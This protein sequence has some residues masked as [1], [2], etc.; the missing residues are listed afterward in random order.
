[1]R[2][3]ANRADQSRRIHSQSLGL[4]FLSEIARK[5]EEEALHFGVESLPGERILD[6]GD[7]MSELILHRLRRDTA[8]RGLEVEVRSTS[9]AMGDG[10]EGSHGW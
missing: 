7:E 2:L 3:C 4:S 10:R 9:G 6:G 8:G 1:M 5:K